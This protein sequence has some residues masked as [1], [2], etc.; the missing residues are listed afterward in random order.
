MIQNLRFYMLFSHGSFAESKWQSSAL[1]VSIIMIDNRY[2]HLKAGRMSKN[3]G[4]DV[5][6]SFLKKNIA[7]LKCQE[8]EISNMLMMPTL[9]FV[10]L[11]P[12]WKRLGSS[13]VN[14]THYPH[15]PISSVDPSHFWSVFHP[16]YNSQMRNFSC[17]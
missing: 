15:L 9:L 11:R 3:F 4:E 8:V 7:N 5:Y 10:K 2:S 1:K 16:L 14:L 13:I 17:P 12:L 6:V